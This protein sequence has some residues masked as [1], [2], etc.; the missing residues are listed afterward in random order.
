V[1]LTV[2]AMALLAATP[3]M[4]QTNEGAQSASIPAKAP[5]AGV[6]IL[7]DTKGIDFSAYTA[8]LHH[9]IQRNWE[10]VIPEEVRAP[11]FSKGVVTLRFTVLPDGKIGSMKLE[12]SSG[13]VSLDKAAW[14]AIVSEG[15]FPALPA[16]FHGPQLELRIRF[17]YNMPPENAQPA[18]R[19]PN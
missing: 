13:K 17:L 4:A 9:D 1:V 14:Y 12:G 11:P 16:A 6:E 2:G 10:P 19:S 5:E 7:S 15:Q 3:A 8:R 18:T